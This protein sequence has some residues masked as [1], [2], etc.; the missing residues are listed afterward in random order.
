M[1][2]GGI[3]STPAGRWE[4][5]YVFGFSQTQTIQCVILPQMLRNVLPAI[6]GELEQLLKSTSIIST[7]GV[8]GLTRSGMNIIAPELNPVTIYLSI[9]VMYLMI[10][11]LLNFISY[12]IEGSL[13]HTK[14]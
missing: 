10:S 11:L 2:R 4:S 13:F 5:A 14:K 7:I 12:K 8:L 3:N 9:A 6:T 1:V